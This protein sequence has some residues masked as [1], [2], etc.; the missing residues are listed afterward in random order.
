MNKPRI[1][2]TVPIAIKRDIYFKI[3]YF[4]TRNDLKAEIELIN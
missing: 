3:K 1:I 2:D 4:K